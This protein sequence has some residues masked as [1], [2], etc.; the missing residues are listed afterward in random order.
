MISSQQELVQYVENYLNEGNFDTLKFDR[1]CFDIIAKNEKSFLMLKALYNVD[2]FNEV[3]ATDLK[4]ISSLVEAS[5]LITG[6]CGRNFVIQKNYVYERFE[7]PVIHPITLHNYLNSLCYLICSKKG[8]NIVKIN[9]GL[10]KDARARSNLSLQDL[11]N[12]LNISKKT[13][14]LAEKNGY[15]SIELLKKIESFFNRNL[16]ERENILE[17]KSYEIKHAYDANALE[18]KII[19]ATKKMGYENQVFKTAPTDLIT[20][21]KNETVVLEVDRTFNLRHAQNL[22]SFS[23]FT[24]KP[25]AV[26][27]EKTSKESMDGIALLRIDELKEI[28]N[29]KEFIKIIEEREEN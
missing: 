21:S 3:Q 25:K 13:L 12:E 27:L 22:K 14:Y 17:K 19:P 8:K 24:L 1:L 26:I 11:S 7:I 9:K 6:L 16:K 4:N 23:E 28:D 29:K 5:P 10:L 18:K 20:F 15:I 2:S